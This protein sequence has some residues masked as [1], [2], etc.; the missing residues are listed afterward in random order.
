MKIKR[1]AESWRSEFFSNSLE[2]KSIKN[3]PNRFQSISLFYLFNVEFYSI[4]IDKAL[5]AEVASN[6]IHD[7]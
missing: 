1:E 6:Q 3:V 7:G 2:K 4:R 5:S